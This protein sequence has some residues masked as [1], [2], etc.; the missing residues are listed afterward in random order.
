MDITYRINS[1][2]NNAMIIAFEDG[3]RLEYSPETEPRCVEVIDG[4]IFTTDERAAFELE[5]E[6]KAWGVT[7]A[8][9]LGC[10]VYPG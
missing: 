5:C 8:H 6:M 10:A 2:E 4:K 7:G 9:A 1:N 3:I